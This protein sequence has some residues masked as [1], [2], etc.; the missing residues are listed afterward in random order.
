MNKNIILILVGVV[1]IAAL[2]VWVTQKKQP[3]VVSPAETYSSVEVAG[4][5]PAGKT[6]HAVVEKILQDAIGLKDNG[7]YADAKKIYQQILN[8]QPDYENVEQVQKE[9]EDV[10]MQIILSNV[11]S[12]F[13]V[14]HIVASGDTLGGLAKKYNT[15]VELIKK[16]NGIK[17][18]VIRIGQKL[19]V[20]TA[21][22]NIFVD[23]SQNIL[24]LKV[25]DEALKVYHIS[26]GKD[27]STPVG[28]FTITSKLV[29]PVWF[30]KGVVVP[31]DSPQNV[32]GSRWL[33]F[34]LSGYGIHGTVD[35]DTIG[36]QVT[37]GCMR[38]RNEEVEELYDMI[39]MG[40]KVTIVD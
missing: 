27:N 3:T 8:E 33:G 40:T 20:W 21:P 6:D 26:T 15:T 34:N 31:P 23:K 36:Q 28:D 12:E 9:M 32:L 5:T 24:I 10:N 22:F 4:V 37:A 29:D 1:S 13:A 7:N 14:E 35:P 30:N 18:D 2:T 16:R 25:G 38:L 39:P 17:K 11:P 19:S